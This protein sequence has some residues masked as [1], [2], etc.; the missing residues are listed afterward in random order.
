MRMTEAFAETAAAVA[1]V[2]WLVG[3]V[4]YQQVTKRYMEAR[5]AD[6]VRLQERLRALEAGDDSSED[7][8]APS[9]SRWALISLYAAWGM[10][11]V[12]LAAATMRALSWLAT[13]TSGDEPGTALFCYLSISVGLA[14]VTLLPVAL[15]VAQALVAARRGGRLERR[16]R[17]LRTQA[18]SQRQAAPSAGGEGNAA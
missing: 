2:I 16:I 8:G 3:A 6:E 4:E 14:V 9:P 11:S 15:L 13:P 1:P 12:T 10:V 7:V 5:R 17:E 18:G